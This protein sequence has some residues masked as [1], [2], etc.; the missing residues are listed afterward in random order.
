MIHEW[1]GLNDNIRAMAERLAAEGY[2]ALAVDLYGGEIADE[3]QQARELMQRA[4]GNAQAAEENLRRAYEYL[5][6][7]QGVERVGTIGWCFG[8]AWSLRAALLLPAEIDA[9]VIY[10]G[11]LV[12]DRDRLAT[13]QMPILGLFGELDGGIPVETVREFEAVLESLGKPAEIHV[14]PGADHAFANPSGTR[15]NP[16]AAED[17]WKRTT[18]FLARNL[19]QHD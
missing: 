11:R 13:L 4:M 6:R 16:E 9:T 12:V 15:Y 5:T 14:Y 17:A 8:G 18:E 10:Y 7:E 1:W 19:E 3:P 2:L